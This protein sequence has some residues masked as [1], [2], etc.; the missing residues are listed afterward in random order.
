MT[1]SNDTQ[2]FE[3]HITMA[4]DAM[5]TDADLADALSSVIDRLDRGTTAGTIRD[6][7]GNTVGEFRI[8]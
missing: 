3:L 1:S 4:N 2:R 8:R 6:I 7:N 5:Q